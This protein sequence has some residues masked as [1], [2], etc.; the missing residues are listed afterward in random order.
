[1]PAVKVTDLDSADYLTLLSDLIQQAQQLVRDLEHAA[2]L[3]GLY[4]NASKTEHMV[5]NLASENS[6]ITISSVSGTLL[7]VLRTLNT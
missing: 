6:N 7:N 5:I 4:I 1:M 2:K 3:T